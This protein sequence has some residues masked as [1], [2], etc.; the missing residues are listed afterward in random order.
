MNLTCLNLNIIRLK[1]QQSARVTVPTNST[2]KNL[3]L[4]LERA[5]FVEASATL[6]KWVFINKYNDEC[7]QAS[8][9]I[10]GNYPIKNNGTLYILDTPTVITHDADTVALEQEIER[11]KRENQ[12]LKKAID[13][14]SRNL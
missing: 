6:D 14:L 13:I 11:V 9:E 10:I 2:F 8:D 4:E 3:A 12:S 5:G 1:D 7:Y